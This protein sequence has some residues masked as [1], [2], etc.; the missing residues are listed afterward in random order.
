LNQPAIQWIFN[1]VDETGCNEGRPFFI[2]IM[3]IKGSHTA[4]PPLVSFADLGYDK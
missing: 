4:I 3:P 1:G 2:E